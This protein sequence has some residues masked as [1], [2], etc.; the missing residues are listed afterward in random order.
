MALSSKKAHSLYELTY[1]LYSKRFT[2]ESLIPKL[3]YDLKQKFGSNLKIHV[4]KYLTQKMILNILE[5]RS[6]YELCGNPF[7]PNELDTSKD[8]SNTCN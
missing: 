5:E 6:C 2:D 4:S 3:T 7:C 1:E 8:F